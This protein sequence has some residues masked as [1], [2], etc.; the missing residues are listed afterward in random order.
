[1]FQRT[2]SSIDV[3]ANRPTDPE[4]A[5][6]ARAGLAAAADGELQQPRLRRLRAGGP[7]QRRL[8]R[9]HRQ[10]AAADARGRR[11]ST[12]ARTASPRTVE[13]ADFEK[14][15]E[16]RARVD[17]IVNDPATAEAL[18]PYYRQFCKRPCFHDEYLDTFNR[19]ERHARRHRRAAASSGSPSAASSS[20]TTE[21]E[22]DCLIFATG[23][24]VGTDYTRRAGYEI[25]G[26][27]G[28]TLTEKWAD[29]ASHAARHAHP[30]L[31]ELLHLQ[32]HAVRLHGEL[33]AHARR[34]EHAPRLHPRPRARPR[35]RASIEASRGGR[36]RRGCE[37]IVD[38][39]PVQPRLPRVVHARLLQQRG[40]ARRAQRPQRLLRRR[41][42]RLL[43]GPRRLARRGRPG[44]P[45]ADAL[46]VRA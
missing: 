23:F 24:E 6:S 13:L 21:Y 22:L 33:P 3:R 19:P 11:S 14:M 46:D 39:R 10:A 31:P 29:G 43:Q 38:A 18:K 27:D 42:G 26:R 25:V 32:P 12:S 4:W 37:T 2:P 9:H 15:E 35:R 1:M 20:A 45:R 17:A 40:Q 34:A 28:L 8:D 36:G 16:I 7:R 44:R 30:R 5:A 41:L